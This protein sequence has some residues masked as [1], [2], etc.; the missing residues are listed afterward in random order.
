M[1]LFDYIDKQGKRQSIEAPDA[2]TAI[3]SAKDIMPSSGVQSNPVPN[4]S[5]KIEPTI[6]EAT[7]GFQKIINQ[8][9]GLDGTKDSSSS[10]SSIKNEYIK[11]VSE[12]G[13]PDRS[14]RNIEAMME[15]EIKAT[16]DIYADLM[17][18]A[19]INN[20]AQL[21]S[22]RASQSRGGLIG[23]DFGQA[24]SSNVRAQGQ[25]VLNALGHEQSAVIA[26][27]INE[28]SDRMAEERRLMREAKESSLSEYVTQ[29]GE[30]QTRNTARAGSLV[31]S[32]IAQGIDPTELEE[33]ELAQ[34]AEAYGVSQLD[35]MSKYQE[36]Y[37]APEAEK[38]KETEY[39]NLSEGGSRY[40]INPETG[41][42]EVIAS[43]P[44]TYAPK[45]V[46]KASEPNRYD[47]KTIPGDIYGDLIA[48]TSSGASLGE[49]LGAYPEVNSSY[50]RNLYSDLNPESDEDDILDF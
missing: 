20:Q 31:N 41:E 13:D 49:I 34:L 50:I 22:N 3:A 32:L 39:F 25:D 6:G 37:E 40:R 45:A 28:G 29:M 30:Q 2:G 7:S 12:T 44:K 24:Q 5:T 47:D 43:R 33:E 11:S 36:N 9:S 10:S 27:I 48:D 38:A 17:R 46:T 4:Q 35:I 8:A 19:Q 15:R 26:R 1:A 21:G 16:N 18:K 14:R 23:S 42:A